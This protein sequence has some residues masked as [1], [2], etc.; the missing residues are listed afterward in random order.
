[1]RLA[2]ILVGAAG[3]MPGQVQS[4]LVETAEISATY[5]LAVSTDGSTVGSA[6]FR[7]GPGEADVLLDDGDSVTADGLV[8][9][10]ESERSEVYTSALDSADH[11][12]FAFRRAG[13]EIEQTIEPAPV[14]AVT[15][16]PIT[17]SYALLQ[18]TLTWAPTIAGGAE[19]EIV[20]RGTT[21]GCGT[22]VLDSKLADTGSFA[23]TGADVKVGTT[24][25]PCTFSLEVRRSVRDQAVET[26]LASTSLHATH[27]AATTLVIR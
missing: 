12:V 15:S 1:M 14:F 10:P 18:T 27:V 16:E 24:P 25:P 6:S 20:A 5:E 2:I 21:A 4:A 9:G 23:F 11:H 8:L 3:C 13:E 22:I 26:A 19:I 7:W 17:G